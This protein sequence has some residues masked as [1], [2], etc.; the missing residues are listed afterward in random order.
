MTESNFKQQ[1]PFHLVLILI[2]VQPQLKMLA[3]ESEKSLW[4]WLTSDF[5]NQ[6]VNISVKANFD[7]NIFLG[8]ITHHL[9]PVYM[10]K[11]TSLARPGAER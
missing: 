7:E 4:V 5:Q 8:K 11:N 9:G 1:N 10:R 6:N 3:G 2:K